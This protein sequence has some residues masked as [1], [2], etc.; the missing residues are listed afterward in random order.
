MNQEI[1][2]L[3]GPSGSGKS[4]FA[5]EYIKNNPKTIRV[6]RDDIRKQIVGELKQDY[7][8]KSNLKELENIVTD[9][10][11]QNIRH[12]LL[13]GYSVI[14]DNTHLKSN[15]IQDIVDKYNHLADIKLKLFVLDEIN[16][17]IRVSNRDSITDT[18]YIDKQVR[19]F[20]TLINKENFKLNYPKTVYIPDYKCDYTGWI[21][22]PTKKC[23]LV[24]IDGTCADHTGIRNAYDGSKL[25]LD[26]PIEA[27]RSILN[28][29]HKPKWLRWLLNSPEIIYVSGREDKWKDATIK[30][31]ADNNF[32]F[33]GKI[34]MR[35]TGDSRK[36]SKVKFEIY[37]KHIEINYVPICSIDDRLQV[38][39]ECWNRTGIF[40]L[41][42]NQTNKTF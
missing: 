25:H 6:N 26:K 42:V 16:C 11:H 8:N 10:Q 36:D 24:D 4:T 33:H 1:L 18:S 37:K 20:N 28:M 19:D 34:Y 9:I 41:N 31:L 32:P 13:Q 15:Y 38:L 35:K 27:T 17:K 3:V 14:I 22:Y 12:S 39:E 5:V 23:I 40:T 21:D 30:W 2:V 7:Y 29:I